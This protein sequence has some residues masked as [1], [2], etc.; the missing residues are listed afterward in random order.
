MGTDTPPVTASESTDRLPPARQLWVVR[1]THHPPRPPLLFSLLP[2][3]PELRPSLSPSPSP[4]WR[5]GWC[6]GELE[7][8]STG[9]LWA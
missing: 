9:S 5:M 2:L 8:V 6:P 1:Q 3:H 4:R 7:G